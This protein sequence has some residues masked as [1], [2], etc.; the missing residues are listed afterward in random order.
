MTG[1]LEDLEKEAA[2][3]RQERDALQGEIN[4]ISQ[5]STE[6]QA[7][8]EQNSR[9]ETQLRQA[10]SKL[11]TFRRLLNG[12]DRSSSSS[13]APASATQVQSTVEGS[14]IQTP[15]RRRGST[16]AKDRAQQIF[17]A[18]VQWNQA[19][20]DEPYAITT[21][22]LEKTF[23]INRKAANEFTSEYAEAIQQHHEAIGVQNERFHNRGKNLELIKAFVDKHNE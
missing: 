3:L 15:Q 14:S 21:G 10:Q 6:D 19:H 2:S 12:G 16:K 17:H 9:L 22:L 4:Q 18:I 23:G 1:R 8:R 5:T 20:P 7:L 13:P 11:E